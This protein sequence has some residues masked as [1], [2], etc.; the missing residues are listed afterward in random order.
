MAQQK[1]LQL[2]LDDPATSGSRI[3]QPANGLVKCMVA[4][5]AMAF[6]AGV[7][8]FLPSSLERKMKE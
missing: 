8:T 2:L 7:T 3:R 6:L 1:P 4:A 5:L